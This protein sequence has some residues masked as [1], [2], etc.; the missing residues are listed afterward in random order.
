MGMETALPKI[1]NKTYGMALNSCDVEIAPTK[2][3]ILI[4]FKEG[5]EITKTDRWGLIDGQWRLLKD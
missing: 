2:N 5:G 4:R 3:L 1:I